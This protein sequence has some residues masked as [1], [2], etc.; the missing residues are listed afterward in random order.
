MD[1]ACSTYGEVYRCILGSVGRSERKYNLKDL[2]LDGR[3][4]LKWIMRKLDE[5]LKWFNLPQDRD[6][7]PAIVNAVMNFRVT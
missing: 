6:R 1:R 3:I 7:W 5:H 4:I 2:G